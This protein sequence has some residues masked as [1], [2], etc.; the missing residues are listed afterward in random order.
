MKM[1]RHEYEEYI[2]RILAGGMGY[3]AIVDI[4]ESLKTQYDSNRSVMCEMRAEQKAIK[5]ICDGNTSYKDKVQ[6]VLT[7]I[8]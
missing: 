5:K 2:R 6:T 4:T 3:Q 7:M 1:P 8:T